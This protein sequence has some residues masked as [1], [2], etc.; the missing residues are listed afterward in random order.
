[1]HAMPTAE[2]T[3]IKIVLLAGAM[4]AVIAVVRHPRWRPVFFWGVGS[5]ALAVFVFRWLAEP[6][7]HITWTY[8][9]GGSL[10]TYASHTTSTRGFAMFLA[11]PAVLLIA[12][13]LARGNHA[14]RGWWI[15]APLL[16][17]TFAFSG[18]FTVSRRQTS[19]TPPPMRLPA[20]ESPVSVVMQLPPSPSAPAPSVPSPSPP[21]PSIDELWDQL[22][23]PQIQL[24]QAKLAEAARHIAAVAASATDPP[25]A[26]VEDEHGSDAA[27]ATVAADDAVDA[28][29]EAQTHD[30]A[31]TAAPPAAES[32]RQR[33][34]W[35]GRPPQ[36]V[37]GVYRVA[38][39]AGP[40]ATIAE[41]YD[42]LRE[43][44]RRVVQGRIADLAR[45][46]TGE[47]YVYV[48]ELESMRIGNSYIDREL[49]NQDDVY[50]ETSDSSVGPMQT[51]WVLLEFT[52]QHDRQLVDAWKAYARRDRIA[53]TAALSG[54]V[55]A[56][57]GG[58]FA[59]LKIDTWTR[60]YYTKRLFLGVPAAII[61]VIALIAWN[62]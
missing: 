48:P 19:I 60:G 22:N 6:A 40:Y 57:L 18:F 3:W 52:E 9:P 59:L 61:A 8:A 20:V 36:T 35:V 56:V 10:T 49:R 54:L 39:E 44:T 47:T 12:F 38:V 26:V 25:S 16:L 45:E 23:A 28:A 34:Q 21:A 13:F 43:E 11:L 58:V 4:A 15:V 5:L 30:S 51:A 7:P 50:V 42:K 1:M 17:A 53:A 31:S 46:A 55:L 41:C 29:H 24:A 32:S 62:S 27:A 14:H 2:P 33:P 37:D